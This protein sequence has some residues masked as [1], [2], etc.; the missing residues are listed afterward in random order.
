MNRDEP[1]DGFANR[2]LKTA[3]G[4]F[5]ERVLFAVFTTAG[6]RIVLKQIH[7]RRLARVAVVI[8]P[9]AAL[10]AIQTRQHHSLQQRRRSEALLNARDPNREL[11]RGLE[12]ESETCDL[13]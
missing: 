10:S 12:D 7:R 11:D 3:A 1:G 2:D 13:S 4:P 9:V 8:K 5:D 6:S